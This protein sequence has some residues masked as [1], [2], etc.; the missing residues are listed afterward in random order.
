MD[1]LR[2][3]AS[4]QPLLIAAPSSGCG[5]TTVTLG[6]L[7]ALRRRGLKVAPFKVGPDYIDPGLHR[8]A[9]GRVSHNLDGWM[10]G[11]DAVK[12]LFSRTSE[13]A[14]VVVI[15]G[16][17]GLFDGASGDSD[18]GSSAEIAGWLDGRILL[19]VDARSQARSVAALISGFCRFN[20]ELEW[21]GVILNRVGSERHEQLLRDACS[22]TPGLPPVLGCLPRDA[23]IQLPE[24]HLGLMTAEE[25]HL[26]AALLERLADWLEEHV[27]I[28]RLLAPGDTN[29]KSGG[30]SATIAELKASAV[31]IGIARDAAFCFYYQDNL[32][33]LAAAGAELVPISPLT[34]SSLPNDLDGIILGGGYPELYAEQLEANRSLRNELVAQV[35]A[36]L[37]LYAE[38]G[39]LLYLCASL[40]GAEMTGLFPATPKLEKQRRALGYREVTLA[41]DCLLGP[42]GTVL[43][44]HE[45]H[46]TDLQMPEAVKRVYRV[47]RADGREQPA[48]G[49]VYKNCLGSYIHLHFASCPAVAEQLVAACREHKSGIK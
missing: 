27:D 3:I 2:K 47:S 15:E 33:R 38:C 18:V 29:I 44:G 12:S 13:D 42:T 49:F 25:G 10:C 16:V 21:A 24:R 23:E 22:S 34:D 37:P 45:F 19:V 14:D 46:Y 26:D 1:A 6:L 8:L 48:E 32:D 40:D 31:R 35:E 20:P 28:E 41:Q 39:G 30:D 4:P 5:K 17:M 36:G 43:R 9:A 7:A 11:E